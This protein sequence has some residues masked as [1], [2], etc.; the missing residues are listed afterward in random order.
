M[1]GL[2]CVGGILGGRWERG[3]GDWGGE[4]ERGIGEVV[5]GEEGRR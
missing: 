4:W 3:I 5:W 1:E 2:C